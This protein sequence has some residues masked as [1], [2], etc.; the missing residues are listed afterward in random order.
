[1]AP[2][3]EYLEVVKAAHLGDIMEL[4]LEYAES[5]GFDLCFQHF[6]EELAELPGEYAPPQGRL[7]L[8]LCGKKKIGCAALRRFSEGVCEM[9][10]LYVRPKFR[11]LG[12]GRELTLKIIAAAKEIG[13][14][15]MRLDTIPSMIEATSLYRS[16]G[17]RE[18]P[19]YRHNPIQGCIFMELD[20]T[21]G[22]SC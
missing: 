9:K 1:V 10:R 5:L 15:R 3:I 14:R 17:F 11:G 7:L 21:E 13:Y 22:A 2:G 18:I 4:F 19:S 16:I 12:I 8:A 6:G 20:L